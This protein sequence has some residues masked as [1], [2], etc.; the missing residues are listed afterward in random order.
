M[1]SDI[2]DQNGLASPPLNYVSYA[3]GSNFS[4]ESYLKSPYD[5]SFSNFNTPRKDQ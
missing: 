4:S 5:R 2:T 1:N 3:T